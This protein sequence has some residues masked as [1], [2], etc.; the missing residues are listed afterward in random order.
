VAGSREAA[1]KSKMAAVALPQFLCLGRR[2]GRRGCHSNG[3]SSTAVAHLRRYFVNPVPPW[4]GIDL[5]SRRYETRMDTFD[6][7]L[8]N[9][10]GHLVIQGRALRPCSVKADA[11]AENIW[12]AFTSPRTDWTFCVGPL[13]WTA[14]PFINRS[15]TNGDFSLFTS[16]RWRFPKQSVTTKQYGTSEQMSSSLSIA[17]LNDH[18][19]C[20]CCN[21]M[22]DLSSAWPKNLPNVH[23]PTLTHGVAYWPGAARHKPLSTTRMISIHESCR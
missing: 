16:G 4:I 12:V 20:P 15:N 14:D 18:R 3:C 9:V 10:H 22:G 1:H 2:L 17:D 23:R 8:P 21:V 13:G 5:G 7:A 11:F 6:F 19:G